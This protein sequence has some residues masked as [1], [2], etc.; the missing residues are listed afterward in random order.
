MISESKT[1]ALRAT[2]CMAPRKP[3]GS[4]PEDGSTEFAPS[5]QWRGE[6]CVVVVVVVVAAA[7]AI[8]AFH[9]ESFRDLLDG[10]ALM[11]SEIQNERIEYGTERN[12]GS[13]FQ[14]W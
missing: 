14:M 12:Y 9:E 5:K 6:K 13:I 7:A 10:L 1:V 11:S 2:M 3:R 4:E 8:V